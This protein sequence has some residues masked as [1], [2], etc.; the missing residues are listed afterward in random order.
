M[1][2]ASNLSFYSSQMIA[3]KVIGAGSKQSKAYLD[4]DLNPRM[5]LQGFAGV[6]EIVA[7]FPDTFARDVILWARWAIKRSPLQ[8]SIY[9]KWILWQPYLSEF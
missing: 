9:W 6:L 8:I 3:R 7:H 5:N 4:R 1:N 2:V